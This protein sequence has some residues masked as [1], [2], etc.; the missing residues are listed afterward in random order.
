VLRA[1]DREALAASSG[2]SQ[3]EVEVKFE[4]FLKDHPNGKLRKKH[5]REMISQVY[6]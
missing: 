5:F 6:F 2:L 3:E 4:A 1:Q